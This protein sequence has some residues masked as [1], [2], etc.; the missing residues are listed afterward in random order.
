MTPWIISIFTVVSVYYLDKWENKHIRS[1]FDWVPAILLAY[2][3]P[4]GISAFLRMDFSQADI[5]EYSKSFFIPLAIVAVMSSLSI[6][7][8]KSIGWKPILLFVTGSFWIAV[9]PIFLILLL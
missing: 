7:Q 3:I 5:H 8:L 2:L 1:L 9:F 6:G 4:A